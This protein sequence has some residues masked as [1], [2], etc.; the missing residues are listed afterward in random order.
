M[1]TFFA[2]V[3]ALFLAYYAHR[4]NQ[5]AL[6]ANDN[7]KYAFGKAV[8]IGVVIAALAFVLAGIALR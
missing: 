2:F 5:R 8:A 1:A 4:F 6:Q 3:V 7:T